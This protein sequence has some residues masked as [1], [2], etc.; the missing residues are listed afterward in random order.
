VLRGFGFLPG[1]R[2]PGHFY[3]EFVP[4]ETWGALNL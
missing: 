3:L 4:C 2:I 1:I